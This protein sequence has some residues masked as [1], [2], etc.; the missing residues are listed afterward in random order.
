MI[1]IEGT[2]RFSQ[3]GFDA[4]RPAMEAMIHATR[5]EDGCREYSFSVDLLDAE[6]IWV[7]ERWESRDALGA[8]S[9]SPHMAEWRDTA[10]KIGLTE[11]SLRLYE[12]EPEEL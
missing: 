10:E 2:I 12:A 3:G 5:A 8:H 7:N 11:R 1:V 4:A 9:R 6:R